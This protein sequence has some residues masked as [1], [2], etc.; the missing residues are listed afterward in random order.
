M[1]SSAFI[2]IAIGLIAFSIFHASFATTYCVSTNG[3]D[4]S[5]NGTVESPWRTLRYA[6]TQ[7]PAGE[8]HLIQLGAGIFVENG[9]VEVPPSVSIEG[10]GKD[11]TIIK[12][13][14]SFF[15]H[16]ADPGYATDKFLIR[17]YSFGNMSGNQ[18][19]RNFTINGDSKKL[20]GGIF[21]CNRDGVVVDGVKVEYTNFTGIWLWN[22]KDSKII[23]SELVNCSWGSTGY[24]S[25]AL[26]IGNLER[27]EIAFLQVDEDT[28]YGIKAIGPDSVNRF[29][30]MVIHDSRISVNPVGL[31]NDGL[32]PNM[33]IELWQVKLVE[34]EIYNCYV[35]NTISLVNSLALPSNGIRTMRV[36]HN[37]LDI[38][39]RAEGKGYGLELT[40][41]DVEVDHNYFIKG[42]YGI[43]N[44]AHAMQNWNIHHNIFY[45]LQGIYPGDVVRSQSSGLHNVRLYN[46]TVEFAGDKTMN[47]IGLYGGTSENVEV[48]NNLFINNTTSY[49]YYP[50]SVIHLEGG[51]QINNLQVKN[52]LL[53]KLSIGTISG[54]LYVNNLTGNPHINKTG[55][56]ADPHYRPKAG[57]PLI[58][59]GINTGFTYNGSAPD[60]GAFEYTISSPRSG[61]AGRS[62]QASFDE[63]SEVDKIAVMDDHEDEIGVFPNPVTGKIT[64]RYTSPVSQQAYIS[65]N[66]SAAALIN[67]ITI[68][69]NE[70]PNNI[71]LDTEGLHNGIYYLNFQSADGKKS[72]KRILI[73]R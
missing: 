17:L 8:G 39:T 63:N 32:A 35:D 66:D 70:G 29:T 69:A 43:A 65:I 12:A 42:T 58:D 44:W 53:D 54:G 38:E 2:K 19:L 14:S 9:L 11:V 73:S 67:Q 5:G 60:I 36:H 52:N 55:E 62:N 26:N 56:R 37:T 30:N 22:S 31:W 24:S 48:I 20:H 46:N 34:C 6:V 64:I 41:H 13:D 23:N 50:N 21:I 45:A 49:N 68:M 25:G 1:K 71:V 15:H 33:A 16:P 51:A 47:V 3:D 7:V 18:S 28:G 4:V 40:I 27:V 59:A 10:A 57:S 61:E 72:I